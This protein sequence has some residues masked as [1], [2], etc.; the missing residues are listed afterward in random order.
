MPVG[1]RYHIR[2]HA[3]RCL[4]YYNQP[5]GFPNF[6]A[7]KYVIST[8]QTRMSTVFVALS[9][10]DAIAQIKGTDALLCDVSNS[11]I[12]DRL[13]SRQGWESH[14]PQRWHRNFI[15]RFYGEYPPST[16]PV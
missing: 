10:L 14:R 6:L 3:D 13:L 5:R 7:I 4:L 8:H 12:S 9:V 16:L 15:K 11:R 2:G 1:R